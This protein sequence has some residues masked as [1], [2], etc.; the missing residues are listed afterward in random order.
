MSALPPP[1]KPDFSKPVLSNGRQMGKS[2][3]AADAVLPPVS[4]DLI[5]DIRPSAFPGHTV[6]R[7]WNG[8]W[9]CSCGTVSSFYEAPNLREES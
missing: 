6:V 8:C 9:V 3:A 2:A 5:R 4:A 7:F 1:R